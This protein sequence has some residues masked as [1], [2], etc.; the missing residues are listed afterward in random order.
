MAINS[1][2]RV[3]FDFEC[4]SH[5]SDKQEV[6]LFYQGLSEFFFSTAKKSKMFHQFNIFVDAAQLLF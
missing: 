6:I 2:Q 1:L 5:I 3:H 4:E